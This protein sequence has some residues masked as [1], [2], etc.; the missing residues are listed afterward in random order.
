M[1]QKNDSKESV[2]FS[3]TL[4]LVVEIGV[5]GITMRHIAKEANMA[6]GTLYIYFKDKETLINSLYQSCREASVKTYFEGYDPQAPF[7][8][9]FFVIWHNILTYRTNNF[10]ESVFMEQCYHSPFISESTKKM[11][12][13][14]LNPLIQLIERGKEEGLL[15]NMDTF[16]LLIF[17][18]GSITEVIKYSKY[19]NHVITPQMAEEAFTICWDGLKA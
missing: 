14:T 6:T 4:K 16:L 18:M 10:K 2:I 19:S 13:H 9:G 17:M 15:K 3:A 12:L 11:M 7:K 8:K 5:A 1:K